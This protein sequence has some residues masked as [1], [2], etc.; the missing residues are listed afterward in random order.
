MVS[1]FV[2]DEEVTF[3]DTA[4]KEEFHDHYDNQVVV[5][6]QVEDDYS[7]EISRDSLEYCHNAFNTLNNHLNANHVEDQSHVQQ[8]VGNHCCVKDQLC[9]EEKY[10]PLAS[11]FECS[12]L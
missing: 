12:L 5:L 8:T 1:E 9:I 11:S 4:V 10:E 3:S 2:E 6:S 7:D